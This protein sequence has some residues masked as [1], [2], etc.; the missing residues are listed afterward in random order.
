MQTVWFLKYMV[1]TT[2]KIYLNIEAVCWKTAKE[3]TEVLHNA[4]H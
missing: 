2:R 4:S 1:H 3:T